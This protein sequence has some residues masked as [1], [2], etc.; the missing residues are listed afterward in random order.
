MVLKIH[1]HSRST[2]TKRVAVVLLE[3]NVKFE[4]IPTTD[5]KTDVYKN[6]MQPFGQVPV[7]EDEGYFLFESRAIGRY[8]ALKYADQGTP[9]LIPIGGDLRVTGNFEKAM[10][11]EATQ[12]TVAEQLIFEAV[13]K[14]MVDPKATPD[15]AVIA[16]LSTQFKEKMKAYEIILSKTKYLAGDDVTLADL[17]HL[18][19]MQAVVN[20]FGSEIL[21]DTPKVASWFNAISSRKSW[22]AIQVQGEVQSNL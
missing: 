21:A 15:E 7:L 13:I 10:A 1:G 17:Y 19:Y 2:C 11:I 14:A 22:A 18:P 5:L 20:K 9:N 4:L 16:R 12:F 6:T 8:I 3:K